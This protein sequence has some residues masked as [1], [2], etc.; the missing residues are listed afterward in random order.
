MVEKAKRQLDEGLSLIFAE[1]I[2]KRLAA[3]TP[4][5]KMEKI[6]LRFWNNSNKPLILKSFIGRWL[7]EPADEEAGVDCAALG[8]FWQ[9]KCSVA[10]TAKGRLVVYTQPCDGRSGP[11][12]ETF[13]SFDDFKHADQKV[14]RAYP[15]SITLATA[16]ALDL[17]YEIELDI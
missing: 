9:V 15:E 1:C 10:Q 6:V 8:N 2:R 12:M 4:V 14:G 7:V 16:A 5:R 17:P 13:D 3:S 11:A